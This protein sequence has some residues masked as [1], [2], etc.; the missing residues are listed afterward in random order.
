MRIVCFG[1]SISIVFPRGAVS[2]KLGRGFVN[3]LI[4]NLPVKLH[5]PDYRYCVPGTTV[6]KKRKSTEP[7]FHEAIQI[8]SIWSTTHQ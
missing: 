1:R 6:G 8:I 2:S 3:S 7:P 5:L 4:S